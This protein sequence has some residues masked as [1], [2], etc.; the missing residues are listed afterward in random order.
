MGFKIYVLVVKTEGLQTFC[1]FE[2]AVYA[3]FFI[4]A[5]TFPFA[6]A[7]LAFSFFDSLWHVFISELR[8]QYLIGRVN[9]QFH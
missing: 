2:K 5:S 7:A 6:V 1:L 3:I 8:I 9:W 4:A